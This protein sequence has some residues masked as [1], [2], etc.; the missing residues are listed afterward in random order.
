MEML[1]QNIFQTPPYVL[2][3]MCATAYRI[4]SIYMLRLFNDPIAVTLFYAATLLWLNDK[5]TVGC[6]VYR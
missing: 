1:L 5:W 6:I 3:F 4:H 2:I